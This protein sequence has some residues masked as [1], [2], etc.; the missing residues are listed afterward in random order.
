VTDTTQPGTRATPV[1]RGMDRM[2]LDAAYNNSAAVADSDEWLADWRIRSMALR[3]MHGARLDVAYGPQPRARFDYLPAGISGAPLFVFIHGGYWQRND[4]DIF[5]FIAEGPR[6]HGI[7]VAILGYTL[8]PTARLSDIVQEVQQALTFLARNADQFGFNS[9]KIYVGGWSAGGH[10]AAIACQQPAVRGALAISGI[11]DLEPIALTYINEQLKLDGNE[12]EALSP[13][14]LLRNGMAPLH[15]AV[16]GDE[17]SELKRQSVSFNEMANGLGLP[18]SLRILPGHHHF[19]I[20]D[21][22]AKPGGMLTAE[23]LGL[24]SRPELRVVQS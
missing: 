3:A 11:F 13:V 21:E 4:K 14:R 18:V 8:A 22:L 6:A 7:D 15:L 23:L 1:Y 5:S 9:E 19:S 2:S 17:L 16:G 24:I 10:L 20:L 12:I